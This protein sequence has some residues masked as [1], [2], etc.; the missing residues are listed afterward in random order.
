VNS[1]AGLI[2]YIS[3]GRPVPREAWFLAVGAV[4]AGAVGSRLGSRTFPIRTI[5]VMLATV[6]VVAAFKLIFT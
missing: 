5:S 4:A 3:S 1:I 2:G 6:L